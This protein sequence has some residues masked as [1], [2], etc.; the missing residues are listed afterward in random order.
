M[1]LLSLNFS[2]HPLLVLKTSLSPLVI[3]HF[4][5]HVITQLLCFLINHIPL[6]TLL[7]AN[8]SLFIQISSNFSTSSIVCDLHLV[9]T[10]TYLTTLAF[11]NFS[12]L[13]KIIQI[14]GFCHPKLSSQIRDTKSIFVF[15]YDIFL[16]IYHDISNFSFH[17]AAIILFLWPH[18]VLFNNLIKKILRNSRKGTV[19]STEQKLHS[20]RCSHQSLQSCMFIPEIQQVI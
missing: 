16:N 2:N 10:V 11:L 6:E 19:H 14:I 4:F 17:F 3:G 18:G 5:Y 20:N 9:I 12:L 15:G 7:P 8:I 1:P 13:L